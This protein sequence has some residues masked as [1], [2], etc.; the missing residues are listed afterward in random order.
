ML[1]DTEGPGVEYGEHDLMNW[2]DDGGDGVI[3][4]ER[5]MAGMWIVGRVT[6]LLLEEAVGCCARELE[7]A[8]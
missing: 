8:V 3:E 5:C 7:P 6:C 1:D 4:N 2:G